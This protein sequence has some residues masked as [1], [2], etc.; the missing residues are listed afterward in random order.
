MTDIFSNAG[1]KVLRF[2]ETTKFFSYFFVQQLLF[3]VSCTVL[4]VLSALLAGIRRNLRTDH[5]L[6]AAAGKPTTRHRQSRKLR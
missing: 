3:S 4:R 5:W 1:A 2:S 6:F